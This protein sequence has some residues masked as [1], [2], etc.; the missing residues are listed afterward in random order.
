MFTIDIDTNTLASRL[1]AVEQRQLPFAISLGLNRTAQEVRAKAQQHMVMR[2]FTFRS[3]NSQAWAIKQVAFPKGAWA[4]KTRPIAKV[5]LERAAKSI[6]DWIEQ[7]HIKTATRP[8]P[9]LGPRLAIPF[10]RSRM[11]EIPRSMFP[12]NLGLQSRRNTAPKAKTAWTKAS[13]K[14]KQRTFVVAY[15]TGKGLIMQRTAR[16]RGRTNVQVL[17]FLQTAQRI[18]ARPW[19]MPIA[20]ET[21]AE[22]L[23]PNLLQALREALATAR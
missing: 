16:G 19:F 14:G 15:G 23:G 9:G 18:R 20:T 5:F 1:T 13:A 7:G 11:A 2:G 8:I 17:F 4:T 6:L 10:R 22:R 3:A 12:V 21:A